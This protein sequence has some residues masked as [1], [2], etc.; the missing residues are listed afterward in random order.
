[1]HFEVLFRLG[2][3]GAWQEWMP[4]TEARSAQ[5]TSN[6]PTTTY[7]FRMRALAEQQ[8]KGTGAWPNHRYVGEW[9]L[10]TAVNFNNHPPVAVDDNVITPEDTPMQIDVL[11]NDSDPDPGATLSISS[12]GPAQHGQVSNDGQLVSYSPDPDYNGTDVFTYTITDGGLVS[13]PGKV[14]VTVTPVDDPPRVRNV[15]TRMNAVGET[16]SFWLGVYDPENEPLTITASNLP[17]GLA[18]DE[19][20]STIHGTLSADTR[21]DPAVTITAADP[22]ATTTVS[23]DWLVLEQVWRAHLPVLA[24]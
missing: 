6:V 3:G 7:Y 1:L 22:Q 21:P 14:T 9:T 2:S 8:P 5:F 15:W 16:V 24:R 10:P 12:A 19:G 23:F 20:S 4:D 13:A 18:L 17:P 11:A